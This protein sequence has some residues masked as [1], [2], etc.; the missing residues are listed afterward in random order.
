MTRALDFAVVREE[1]LA[2]R[3]GHDEAE[4]LV[5]VEPLH[6]TVFCFQCQS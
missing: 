1:V 3:L 4:A 2:A 6:D 5:V